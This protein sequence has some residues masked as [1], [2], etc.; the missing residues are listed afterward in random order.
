VRLLF[1]SS[2]I[3]PMAKTGGLGDV[4]ASLPA[5]LAARDVD[6]RL[7]MPGYPSALRAVVDVKPARLLADFEGLGRA[8]I[9]EA[10]TPD[11]RLPIWL[12]RCPALFERPGHPYADDRGQ[13]W[14]DN[15]ERFALF[16][17]AAAVL[18]SDGS[19]FTWRPDV[20]HANDWHAGLVV[21]L[22]IGRPDRPRLLF[23]VHNIAFQG[24]F[25]L[26]LFPLCGLAPDMRED[27]GIGYGEGF[28]LLKAGVR[29]ADWVTTVSPTYAREIQ[30]PEFGFG[31]EPLIA[32]RAESVSGILNGIDV[33]TW[34]PANDPHIAA[35]YSTADLTGKRAC[36]TALLSAFGL[37]VAPDAPLFGIVSRLTAQKGLD[38]VPDALGAALGAGARLAAVGFGEVGIEQRFRDLMTRSPDR[39]SVRFEFD[40]GLAHAV[41]AGAD[42]FLMPSRFEPSGLN[43]MYSQRYGTPP[44]VHAVGGLADSVVDADVRTLHDGSATGFVFREPSAPALAVAINRALALFEERERW[45]ALQLA[46]M[47]R[48][49]S[50]AHAAAQYLDLY[51]SL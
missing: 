45:R 13:S 35:R 21:A 23:T 31:F 17:R 33:T 8:E 38:L 47:R 49:F 48:D 20:V 26:E 5:A 46:G 32:A 25:P 27:A 10:L 42:I 4:S 12:I 34:D 28:S 51:D 41:E 3:F 18:A 15:F 22:L 37:P 19:P 44:I 29:Y 50:W 9:V 16:S 7:V 36:K 11:S 43:Q 39:V 30:T 6:V 24:T 2:E 40:E 1:V 14:P